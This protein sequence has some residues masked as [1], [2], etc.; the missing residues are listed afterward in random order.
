MKRMAFRLVYDGESISI[1]F[2]D[3]YN[4]A[5]SEILGTSASWDESEVM[6]QIKTS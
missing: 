5:Q 4:S 6:C 3:K 2:M 1:M